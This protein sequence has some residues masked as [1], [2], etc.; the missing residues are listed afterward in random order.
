MRVYGSHGVMAAERADLRAV[1]WRPA[2]RLEAAGV[3]GTAR[4]LGRS[5]VVARELIVVRP[6]ERLRPT[7]MAELLAEERAPRVALARQAALD[8]YQEVFGDSA[9]ARR[10]VAED[11]PWGDL[12]TA[13]QDA[14]TKV[15]QRL[16][17]NP[18]IRYTNQ[19]PRDPIV[20][21]HNWWKGHL[22]TD[23]HRREVLIEHAGEL[24]RD[25]AADLSFPAGTSEIDFFH[26]RSV[27]GLSYLFASFSGEPDLYAEGLV[28]AAQHTVLSRQPRPLFQPGRGRI[29]ANSVAELRA[30]PPVVTGAQLRGVAYGWFDA[31]AAAYRRA[32]VACDH[33]MWR[34][35][36][37]GAV[38]RA[39]ART[40]LLGGSDIESGPEMTVQR[41][42]AFDVARFYGGLHPADLRHALVA[43]GLSMA[44]GRQLLTRARSVLRGLRTD[45]PGWGPPEQLG[46]ERA[47]QVVARLPL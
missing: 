28:T 1:S 14:V 32:D 20:M 43:A 13:V 2:A 46:L 42:A 35:A 15:H 7:P 44:T 3:T 25:V 10:V 22:I 27:D 26:R 31:V 38:D 11:D 33:A 34:E 40:Q 19:P 18:D 17:G 23:G 12:P 30:A 4:I 37:D 16:Q 21:A 36:F 5:G 29:N 45:F 41:R 8:R 6:Y 24:V 39:E 47:R 9:R